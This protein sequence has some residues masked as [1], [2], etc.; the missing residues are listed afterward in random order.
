MAPAIRA[1]G[2]QIALPA[3]RFGCLANDRML[4]LLS[5]QLYWVSVASLRRQGH[6]LHP[7]CLAGRGRDHAM[8]DNHGREGTALDRSI[9][10][11]HSIPCQTRIHPA[12]IV[13]HSDS[14]IE[15]SPQA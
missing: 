2:V 10:I 5:I 14:A 11:T 12:Y 13:C 1:V 6:Q 4:R 3:A 8:A 9:L 7:T 15:S